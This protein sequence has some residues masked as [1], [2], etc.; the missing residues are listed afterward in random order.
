MK[1][2][3][4]KII[5]ISVLCLFLVTILAAGFSGNANKLQKQLDEANSN[6]TELKTDYEKINKENEELQNKY[7]D[8][9]R[10]L[11]SVK[12]ELTKY[13]DQKS[14]IVELTKQLA[15]LQSQYDS[16]KAENDSLKIQLSSQ[17]ADTPSPTVE[18]SAV[19]ESSSDETVWLSATGSKYHSIPDCGNMNPNKARQTTKSSAEASGYGRCS[20]CW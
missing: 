1:S 11:E 16:V 3:R 5:S 18:S 2:R 7:N 8:N 6:Y 10:D 12:S 19:P 13:K 14:Q 17:Q 4:A 9:L 20:N 15:D